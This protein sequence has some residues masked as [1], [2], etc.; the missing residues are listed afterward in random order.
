MKM[1]YHIIDVRLK[2]GRTLS[3]LV[4]QGGRF[5]TG[6]ETD[7]NGMGE[8]PFRSEDI[9]NVRR[10]ALVLGGLWPFWPRAQ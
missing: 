3:R 10:C 8:L 7:F 9:A 2:D 4:V 1:D 5:V 6:R